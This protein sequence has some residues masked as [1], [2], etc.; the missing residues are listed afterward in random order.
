MV[1]VRGKAPGRLQEGS[2]IKRV[3]EDDLRAQMIRGYSGKAPGEVL[4]HLPFPDYGFH[5]ISDVLCL[6]LGRHDS[7]LGFAN[8]SNINAF[9]GKLFY[10]AQISQTHLPS[11]RTILKEI[12]PPSCSGK[13]WPEK[14]PPHFKKRHNCVPP[15]LS[16]K[17]FI[18]VWSSMSV[19]GWKPLFKSL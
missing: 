14:T 12:I 2:R 3:R 7:F 13:V 6:I 15:P 1:L 16:S 8:P 9:A 17:I 18:T 4:R 11:L 10:F 5:L 19:S